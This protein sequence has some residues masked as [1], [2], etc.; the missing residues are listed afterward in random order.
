V[1]TAL[2]KVLSALFDLP[3]PAVLEPLVNRCRL[4]G[5][6]A[7]EHLFTEGEKGSSLYFILEGKLA[8]HKATSMAGKRQAVALLGAG[9]VVGE[10]VLGHKQ[11][12]G[13]TLV[14]VEK[15]VLAE[16]HLSGFHEIEK[17][18]PLLAIC[19][20]KKMLYLS[21]VRLQKSSERLALIL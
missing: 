17:I 1:E 14:A 4:H 15:S 10:G 16:L 6:V 19:I 11:I 18:D 21:S 5:L 9:S 20:V 12:R 2:H 7:G 13:A 3:D 8:V